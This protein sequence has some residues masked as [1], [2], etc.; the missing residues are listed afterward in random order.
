MISILSSIF[1]VV[2]TSVVVSSVVV[3]FKGSQNISL[4]LIDH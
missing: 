3:S 2:G 1:I 4:Y